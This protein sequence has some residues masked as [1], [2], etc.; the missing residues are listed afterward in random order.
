MTARI[1]RQTIGGCDQCWIVLTLEG[2]KTTR[3]RLPL[4]L[5]WWNIGVRT[6]DGPDPLQEN[7]S[8]QTLFR[9][10]RHRPEACHKPP[11]PLHFFSYHDHVF[12][13]VLWKA[14]DKQI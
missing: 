6:D 14:T 7:M 3:E 4:N 10:R 11:Q 13:P 2:G 9:M 5:L 8:H 12:R 1:V